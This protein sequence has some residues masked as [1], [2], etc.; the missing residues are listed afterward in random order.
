MNKVQCSEINNKINHKSK[1]NRLSKCNYWIFITDNATT[2]KKD[3]DIFFMSEV[4]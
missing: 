2:E 3:T 4:R 1:G